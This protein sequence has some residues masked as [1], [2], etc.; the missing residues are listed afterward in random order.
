MT[1][2]EYQK[3]FYKDNP[4]KY[5]KHKEKMNKYFKTPEGRKKNRDACR[6]FRKEHPRYYNPYNKARYD[7]AKQLNICPKCYKPTEGNIYCK[8]C[9]T[10]IKK[11][12]DFRK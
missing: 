10:K 9:I 11:Q 4:E 8:V 6:R 3:K 7:L 2:T 1:S 5:K 12:N